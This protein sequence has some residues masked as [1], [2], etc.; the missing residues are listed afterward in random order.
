MVVRKFYLLSFV[1]LVLVWLAQFCPRRL[2]LFFNRKD[3]GPLFTN[4]NYY[5]I[6]NNYVIINN[7]MI[8]IIIIIRD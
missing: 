2:D 8:K 1:R 4:S 5:L 3:H 7:L 6:I